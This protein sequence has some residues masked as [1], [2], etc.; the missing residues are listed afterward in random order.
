WTSAIVAALRRTFAC[1]SL[2]QES[3]FSVRTMADSTPRRWPRSP[4]T[5]RTRATACLSRS[6]SKPAGQ[7]RPARTPA[8]VQ[9]LASAS[10]CSAGGRMS[11]ASAAGQGPGWAVRPR[12]CADI[13]GAVG[14][15]VAA[16]AAGGVHGFVPALTSFVGRDEAVAE[17]A[18]LL[19]EYRLVTVTGPGG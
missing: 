6:R 16:A 7:A 2:T 3:C 5:Y 1:C 8:P 15:S 19:E 14:Q 13:V 18:G 9:L 10:L 11:F 12:R 4:S 17:V